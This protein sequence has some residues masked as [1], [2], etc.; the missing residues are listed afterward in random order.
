MLGPAVLDADDYPEV[1]LES[2]ALAGAT[3]A[4]PGALA[5]SIAAEVRGQWHTVH[6][7][8]RYALAGGTLTVTGEAP[9]RQS[10]LGLTPFT[11][12][13]GALAV[14]DEMRLEVRIVAR[15]AHTAH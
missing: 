1:V 4:Q 8:L 3:P 14:Q 15:A 2:V 10:E 7:P 12:L 5:A 6:M 11:A 13:M 9:L